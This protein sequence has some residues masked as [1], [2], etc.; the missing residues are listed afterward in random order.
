M[1]RC[2]RVLGALMKNWSLAYVE[3]LFSCHGLF[4][5]S[6]T[7]PFCFFPEEFWRSCFNN[8]LL[9]WWP[10]DSMFSL[11][12]HS[13]FPLVIAS[14]SSF[15]P[16]HVASLLEGCPVFCFVFSC[17]HMVGEG[18]HWHQALYRFHLAT[19]SIIRSFSTVGFSLALD[20]SCLV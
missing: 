3:H 15:Q 4:S 10:A 1:V 18:I 12:L 5:F 20:L 16:D 2:Q 14:P 11:H 7:V 6:E 8:N 17:T 13:F 19:F 9:V